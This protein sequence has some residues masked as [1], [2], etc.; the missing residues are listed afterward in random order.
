MTCYLA[1]WSP[2][3]VEWLSIM[4]RGQQL[5][6]LSTI[7]VML[8]KTANWLVPYQNMKCLFIGLPDNAKITG[9]LNLQ[10]E[11]QIHMVAEDD[12]QRSG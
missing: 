1:S 10:W 11:K 9:A 6:L 7:M 3:T 2:L 4:A 5:G 12:A 8:L